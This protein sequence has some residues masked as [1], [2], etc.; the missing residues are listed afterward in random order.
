[1]KTH[2]LPLALTLPVTAETLTRCPLPGAS[3]R[4]DA[5]DD[6]TGW[7]PVPGRAAVVS[8]GSSTTH[9]LTLDPASPMFLPRHASP[10]TYSG[11]HAKLTPSPFLTTRFKVHRESRTIAKTEF[12][13]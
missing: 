3:Y 10:L 11:F 2:L 7:A 5:C 12:A 13:M 8:Q 6:F 4:I 9:I 1:M